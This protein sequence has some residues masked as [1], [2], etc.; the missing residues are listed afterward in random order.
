MRSDDPQQEDVGPS[1]SES[2]MS[3]SQNMENSSQQNE[4]ESLESD[5]IPENRARS[6]NESM[7]ILSQ[8]SGINILDKILNGYQNLKSLR[9]AAYLLLLSDETNP[10]DSRDD[11]DPLRPSNLSTSK[12]LCKIECRLVNDMLEQY[13]YPF[14]LFGDDEK[15][16]LYGFFYERFTNTDR[17]YRT[18]KEFGSA[19]E[20]DRFIMQ[21]GGYI[22][23]GELET[24]FEHNEKVKKN[25]MDVAK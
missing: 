12:K 3:K 21:D 24:Y 16:P 18:Y 9:K 2:G 7:D 15:E 13:F 5:I 10:R 14:N 11:S 25:P 20:D 19:P 17:A 4:A 23:L 8:I 1:T 22:R 6:Q